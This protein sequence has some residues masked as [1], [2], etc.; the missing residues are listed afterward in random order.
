MFLLQRDQE[1]EK[2][3]GEPRAL[4][5]QKHDWF[6]FVPPGVSDWVDGSKTP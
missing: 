2:K 4:V 6:S 5:Q 3:N 1:R